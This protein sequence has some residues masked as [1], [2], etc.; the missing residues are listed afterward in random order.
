MLS[1]LLMHI[2]GS[3]GEPARVKA[4]PGAPGLQGPEG[5]PGLQ[6]RRG[7]HYSNSAKFQRIL[8]SASK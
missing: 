1:V 7:K 2:E 4:I 3:K 8:H 6:G 5:T